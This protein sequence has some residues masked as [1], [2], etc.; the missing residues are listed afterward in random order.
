MRKF[1]AHGLNSWMI[2]RPWLARLYL[3]ALLP[4]TPIIF[5]VAIL[6]QNRRDF[7]EIPELISA[8]FL[9]WEQH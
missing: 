4:F 2:R 3:L 7:R 9:P 1:K 6:W 5:S 8:I